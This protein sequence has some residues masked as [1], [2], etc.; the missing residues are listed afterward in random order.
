M[1]L[2]HCMTRYSTSLTISQITLHHV[3]HLETE[4]IVHAVQDYDTIHLLG[5]VM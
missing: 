5:N 4:R 3:K 1:F 2:T